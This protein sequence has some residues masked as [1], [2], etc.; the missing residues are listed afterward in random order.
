MK[1]KIDAE[2]KKVIGRLKAARGQFEQLVKTQA[3]VDEARKFAEKQQRE[4]K[5]LLNTDLHRVRAF[6]EKEKA[7]LNK[8]QQK[9]PTEVARVR[10][11]VSLQRKDLEK[12]LKGLRKAKKTRA[13]GAA[14]KATSVSRKRANG[15]AS[16]KA[17]T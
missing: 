8:L 16:A 4:V 14:G 17:G 9:L 1:I 7:G 3:W 13:N 12:M 15:G 10:K 2:V 5:K 6:I 11:F